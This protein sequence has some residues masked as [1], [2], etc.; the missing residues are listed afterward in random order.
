VKVFKVAI[1]EEGG[2]AIFECDAIEYVLRKW[3]VPKWLVPKW[4]DNPTEGWKIP[5]RLICLENLPH[6][7]AAGFPFEY[8]V[9]EPIPK[10]VLHDPGPLPL[11]SKYE[12]LFAP[13][14]RIPT[15]RGVH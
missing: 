1:A 10:T 11:G 15:R 7:K 5:E 14:I 2:N 9:S 4:L 6:H 12:V 8:V 3:L 13:D